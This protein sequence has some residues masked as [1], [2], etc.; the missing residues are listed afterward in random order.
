MVL[1]GNILFIDFKGNCNS[2]SQTLLSIKLFRLVNLS[3]DF[4]S[5][6]N[7]LKFPLMIEV[8]VASYY[9]VEFC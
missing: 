4:G 2:L 3:F 8:Y 5:T 1:E 6:Q 9:V 7:L